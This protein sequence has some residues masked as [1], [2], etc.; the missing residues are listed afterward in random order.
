MN[1]V[2]LEKLVEPQIQQLE[3]YLSSSSDS[4]SSTSSSSSES[5]LRSVRGLQSRPENVVKSHGATGKNLEKP[6]PGHVV[7]L[8]KAQRND[9]QVPRGFNN[10]N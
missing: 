9:E 1:I 2:E 5:D 3:N 4:D 10:W 7:F 8:I 6:C